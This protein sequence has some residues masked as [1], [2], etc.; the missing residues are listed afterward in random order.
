VTG[1]YIYKLCAESEW[2]SREILRGS[3]DDR[4]DG[5]IHFSTAEQLPGTLAKH[6]AH[7]RDLAL[8]RAQPEELGDRLRWEPSRGGA[9]FPHVYGELT[10]GDLWHVG[11]LPEGPDGVP[12]LP[13]VWR[14]DGEFNGYPWPPED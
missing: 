8:L 13:D 9:L 10:I 12:Y 14:R 3:A 6:F 1:K 2:Q 11:R 5:F 4:R 7:Q